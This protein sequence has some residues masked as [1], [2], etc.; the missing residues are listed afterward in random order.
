MKPRLR[1]APSPSGYLAHRR[2]ANGPLQLALGEKPGR[3]VRPARRRHRPGAQQHRERARHPRRPPLARAGLGRG[4]RGGRHV[5]PLLPER[6]QG[7]STA[8]TP[9]ELIREGKA[10][11]CYCTKEELDSAREALKAQRSEGAVRLPGHLP[12]AQGRARPAVRR[13]FQDAAR[14]QHRF[15]RPGVRRDQH[16]ERVAA[17]LRARAHRRLPA[18][19]P[20]RHG[21]RPRD[22]HHARRARARPHRQHAAA[23]PALPGASAGSRPSS[24]TCR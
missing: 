15:R 18:L 22:G 6:A 9:S 13:P 1:F 4:S 11:R 23:A 2:R 24:R 19:Q 3:R 7:R 14:G 20:G 12:R 5:R 21:R 17:G 8:S 16:A 10:Y